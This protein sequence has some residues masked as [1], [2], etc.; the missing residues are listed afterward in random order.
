MN[1]FEIQFGITLRHRGRIR[2]KTVFA[3]YARK[4]YYYENEEKV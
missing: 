2:N 1:V 3:E 4:L